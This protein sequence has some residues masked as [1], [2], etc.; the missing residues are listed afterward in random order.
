MERSDG[1][2]IDGRT[3]RRT[4]NRE[5]VLDAVLAIFEEGKL[6]P[7]ID[8]VADRAGVSNRSVYRYFDH[9]DHLIRAATTHALR[10]ASPDMLLDDLG[11]G[12]FEQR[13]R[14]FV[15]HR[16][17]LY[18]KLAPITR[19][20]MVAAVSEPLIAEEFDISRMMLRQQFLDHF[21]D[22]LRHLDPAHQ[23]RAVIMA[24]LPFQFESL[25]YL[26]ESTNGM[27]MEMR[28]ILVA[29]LDAWLSPAAH[30]SPARH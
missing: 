27:E 22:E 13:A 15:D 7:S 11:G 23:T 14:R 2:T 10:K 18:R 20:A 5:A 25:D 29:E 24:E 17:N 9:R 26:W 30:R 4:R 21:A 1:T 19:A 3:M 16:L 6:D 12:S 28:A 8:E